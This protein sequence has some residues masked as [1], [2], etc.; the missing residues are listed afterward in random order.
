MF[1]TK[2]PCGEIDTIYVQDYGNIAVVDGT[3]TFEL[4]NDDGGRDSV[5]ARFTF[6]LK[7]VGGVWK[8]A[9]HHSSTNPE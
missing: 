2:E 4:N 7:Q 6:V 8:I 1:V 3:Y 9:T 5:A